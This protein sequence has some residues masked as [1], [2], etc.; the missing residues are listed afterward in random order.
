MK[1]DTVEPM[2]ADDKYLLLKV[3][4]DTGLVGYGEGG[5]HGVTCWCRK[6]PAS[7]SS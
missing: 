3:V 7:A 1:I 4:T 5:P 2:L 6:L